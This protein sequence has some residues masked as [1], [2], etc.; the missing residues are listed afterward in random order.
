MRK[1]VPVDLA[2]STRY[3][4]LP[5]FSYLCLGNGSYGTGVDAFAV[6]N[7]QVTGLVSVEGS[8]GCGRII[9]RLSLSLNDDRS[10]IVAMLHAD[11]SV[12]HYL[13]NV[14]VSGRD[15]C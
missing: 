7:R 6:V 15:F 2:S 5:G 8:A 4:P 13:F 3:V 11:V 10:A 1:A 12:G 14:Q 9:R